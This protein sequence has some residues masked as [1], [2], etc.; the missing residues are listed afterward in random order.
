MYSSAAQTTAPGPSSPSAHVAAAHNRPVPSIIR[1][2]HAISSAIA[3]RMGEASTTSSMLLA[4]MS[5]QA[6]SSYSSHEVPLSTTS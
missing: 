3:P 6:V 4:P 2:F 1:F 5:D